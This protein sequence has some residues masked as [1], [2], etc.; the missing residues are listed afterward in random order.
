MRLIITLLSCLLAAPLL[1]QERVLSAQKA[2][3]YDTVITQCISLTRAQFANAGCDDLL[4]RIDPMIRA[5]G[6][7][8]IALGRTEWGFGSDVFLLPPAGADISNALHLTLYLRGSIDPPTMSV[9]LSLYK[10]MPQGRLTLWEDSGLG[11]GE[12]S[13]IANALSQGL[14]QKLQPILETLGQNRKD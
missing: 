7:K 1:A 5:E 13:Y 8:H 11:A 3:G 9:W 4:I 14:A 6:L 12:Q 2:A 10:D